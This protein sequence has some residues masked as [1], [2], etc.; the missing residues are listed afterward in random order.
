[1]LSRQIEYRTLNKLKRNR[2]FIFFGFFNSYRHNTGRRDRSADNAH[3]SMTDD[4]TSN[5]VCLAPVF[6]YFFGILLL[7]TVRYHRILF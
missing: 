1:M 4:P 2:D 3:S 5:F 6:Y 7:N